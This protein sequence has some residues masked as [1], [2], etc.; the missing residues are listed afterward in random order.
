VEDQ[1]YER[2]ARF[3]DAVAEAAGDGVADG[4][5]ADLRD[6]KAAGRDDDFLSVQGSGRRGW[7]GL[8]GSGLNEEACAGLR[9]RCNGGAEVEI[10]TGGFREKHVHDLAGGAVAEQLAWRL[11]VMGDAVLLNQR[12][13]GVGGVAGEGGFGEVGV[14][15]EEVFGPRVEVGEVGA[16]SAGD[17]DL[18]AGFAGVVEQR[19]AQAA[20]DEQAR[21][22]EPGGAGTEDSDVIGGGVYK[23]TL[24]ASGTDEGC[25]PGI[26][27]SVSAAWWRYALAYADAEMDWSS[28][29][30]G[31]GLRGGFGGMGRGC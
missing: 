10:D 9:D 22:E 24:G 29:M 11:G 5:G 7:G 1:W 23:F 12:Y 14:F 16:A 15:G 26:T 19:D 21:A 28:G 4:G 2:G 30:C 20:P 6:G 13:K 25:L 27:S 8:R 31:G 17:K 3:H 18:A